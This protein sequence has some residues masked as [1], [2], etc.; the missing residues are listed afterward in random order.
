MLRQYLQGGGQQGQ[1]KA[2][3]LPSNL[4][5]RKVGTAHS[6]YTQ[7]VLATS[8]LLLST[9]WPQQEAP[10]CQRIRYILWGGS[11]SLVPQGQRG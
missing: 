2:S 11:L 5:G 10:V 4:L 3:V 7:R 8:F 1:A 9:T 6:P